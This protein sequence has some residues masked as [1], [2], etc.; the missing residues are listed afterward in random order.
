[1]P[2]IIISGKYYAGISQGISADTDEAYRKGN[3]IITE[4]VQNIRTVLAMNCKNT[5]SKKYD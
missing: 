1:M 4:S 5:I 3:A 2:F